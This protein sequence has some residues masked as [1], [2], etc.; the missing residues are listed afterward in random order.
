MRASRRSQR[1]LSNQIGERR[2]RGERSV[3]TQPPCRLALL[4]LAGSRRPTRTLTNLLVSLRR[5]RKNAPSGRQG[6]KP[7][8]KTQT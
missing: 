5:L 6:L 2:S 1:N 4:K 8:K 7:L 3:S